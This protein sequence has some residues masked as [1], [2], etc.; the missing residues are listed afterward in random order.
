MIELAVPP[1]H[2][3]VRKLAQPGD[4]ILTAIQKEA[5]EN[6]NKQTLWEERHTKIISEMK[7][8]DAVLGTQARNF[9]D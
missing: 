5:R 6:R 4:K 3:Y 1:L 2:V 9:M 7:C 8:F